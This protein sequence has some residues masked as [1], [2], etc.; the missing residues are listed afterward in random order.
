MMH[1]YGYDIAHLALGISTLDCTPHRRS[2]VE[3]LK[4]SARREILRMTWVTKD[5]SILL[6]RDWE[7]SILTKMIV[8]AVKIRMI[9][10]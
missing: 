3:I 5:Y 9:V 6:Y 7:G 2:R 8:T 1:I 10:P 4:D